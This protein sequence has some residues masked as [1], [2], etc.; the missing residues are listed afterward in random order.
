MALQTAVNSLDVADASSGLKYAKALAEYLKCE[1][2]SFFRVQKKSDLT[3]YNFKELVAELFGAT[4]KSNFFSSILDYDDVS[5]ERIMEEND[6]HDPIK[7]AVCEQIM[8]DVESLEYVKDVFD[9]NVELLK[10]IIMKEPSTTRIKPVSDSVEDQVIERIA[11]YYVENFSNALFNHDNIKKFDEAK[12]KV[13]VDISHTLN[14]KMTNPL[15][16]L[17]ILLV[18]GPMLAYLKDDTLRIDFSAKTFDEYVP[19]KTFLNHMSTHPTVLFESF[20]ILVNNALEVPVQPN[21]RGFWLNKFLVPSFDSLPSK[22]F[23]DYESLPDEFCNALHNALVYMG[24]MCHDVAFK[25]TYIKALTE[26]SNKN[27]DQNILYLWGLLDRDAL[28]SSK[29]KQLESLKLANISNEN[30]IKA[31]ERLL[32]KKT[33]GDDNLKALYKTHYEALKKMYSGPDRDV[34]FPNNW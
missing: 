26:D 22:D 17:D 18:V 33:E 12:L 13:T 5:F 27:K 7:I 6:I 29:R 23:Y 31:R 25:A 19:V 15:F 1:G 3:N 2:V 10:R 11:N 30:I 16:T 4:E 20:A 21:I 24:D 9:K 32:T 14:F 34:Q 8:R 28:V